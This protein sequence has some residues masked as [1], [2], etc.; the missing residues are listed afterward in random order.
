MTE[1]NPV[2]AGRRGDPFVGTWHLDPTRCEYEIGA[3]PRSAT[4]RIEP[5]GEA[6]VFTIDWVGADGNA[7]HVVYHSIPD[8]RQHPYPDNPDVADSV[9]TRRVDAHT[10]DTT[11]WKSGVVTGQARRGL[12]ADGQTL[13]ITQSGTTDDGITY[14][15][16]SV[17]VRQAT[18]A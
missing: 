7:A 18:G 1:H 13:T 3:P 4:Y 11:S 17:Y 10:M 6:L 8:G 2:A 16:L 15:N 14:R 9:L 12:S 5:D